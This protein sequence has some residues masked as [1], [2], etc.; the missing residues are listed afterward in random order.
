MRCGEIRHQQTM[1]DR[2]VRHRSVCS[3]GCY[4]LRMRLLYSLLLSHRGQP[5]K[6]QDE[7]VIGRLP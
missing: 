7:A 3:G 6:F 5:D 4:R 2:F 1:I